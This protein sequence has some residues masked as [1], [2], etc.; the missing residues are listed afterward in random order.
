[1]FY[2]PGMQMLIE[3]VGYDLVCYEIWGCARNYEIAKVHKLKINI[4]PILS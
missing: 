1:M 2:I 4:L 3:Q